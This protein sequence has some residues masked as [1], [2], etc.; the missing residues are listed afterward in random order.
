MHS[1]LPGGGLDAHG[2]EAIRLCLVFRPRN[3]KSSEAALEAPTTTVVE[4]IVSFLREMRWEGN[5]RE[6]ERV[7][8]FAVSE[9]HGLTLQVD[10]LPVQTEAEEGEGHEEKGV[11]PRGRVKTVLGPN[12]GIEVPLASYVD[13]HEV[14]E[15]M[16]EGVLARDEPHEETDATT[17]E[18]PEGENTMSR[19]THKRSRSPLANDTWWNTMTNALCAPPPVPQL[20][21]APKRAAS[22]PVPRVSLSNTHPCVLKPGASN[23]QGFFSC[24]TRQ[25]RSMHVLLT[26]YTMHGCTSSSSLTM[27]QDYRV[28]K[29]RRYPPRRCWRNIAQTHGQKRKQRRREV[30]EG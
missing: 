3:Q 22:S 2:V 17:S 15:V 29:Q 19:M 9:E 21:H 28:I 18:M 5:V 14:L 20:V 13:P 6:I 7:D 25:K 16:T 1:R 12:A 10:V 27:S 26:V 24:T 30:A 23:E 4:D 11:L 8:E